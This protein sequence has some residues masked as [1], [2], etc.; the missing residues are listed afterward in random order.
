MTHAAQNFSPSFP[1]DH[2]VYRTSLVAGIFYR[3]DDAILFVNG[4]NHE[5]QFQRELDNK[6]DK[7]ALKVIGI[8]NGASYFIGYVPKD[9]AA[10]IRRSGLADKVKP[11]LDRIFYNS[12]NFIEIRFKVIG[13]KS[14]RKKFHDWFDCKL[15]SY[16]QKNFYKF[17]NIPIPKKLTNKE[18]V[19]T[20]RETY[21]R[22]QEERSEILKEYNAYESIIEDFND[23][24][25]RQD[26]EIKKPRRAVLLEV[27]ETLSKYGYSY[28]F[29]N[30]NIDIVL[31]RLKAFHPSLSKPT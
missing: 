27:L 12:N 26:Y 3:K 14:D 13:L 31:D 22:L 10:Q 15:A 19:E 21:K 5:L 28:Q 23:R 18:A 24:Y 7:D 1:A 11:I 6:H 30:T 4:N 25:F 20:I 17:F 9:L 29:M 2:Q 8:S 16:E